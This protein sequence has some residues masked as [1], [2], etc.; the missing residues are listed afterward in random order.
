MLKYLL[1]IGFGS[2]LGG[3]ARFIVTRVIQNSA[4]TSFPLGTLSVNIIG[5][6]L[7][8]II[9]GLSERSTLINNELRMFLTIGFCGGFTTFSSFT[10]ENILLLRDGNIMYFAL[11]TSISVFIGIFATYAGN[12]LTKIL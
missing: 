5:C 11:Y 3:I 1:L 2:F 8:G 6:F 9:F 10:N 4:S 12:L 7:I